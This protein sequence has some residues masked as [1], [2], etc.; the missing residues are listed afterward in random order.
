MSGR[1]AIGYATTKQVARR[2]LE[3]GATTEHLADALCKELGLPMPR[4]AS[5]TDSAKAAKFGNSKSPPRAAAPAPRPT[6]AQPKLVGVTSVLRAGEATMTRIKF[7]RAALD[8]LKLMPT[9]ADA[10]PLLQV[11]T[12]NASAEQLGA[13]II[14]QRRFRS[15]RLRRHRA[16][17]MKFYLPRNVLKQ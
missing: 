11:Y 5:K 2:L 14:V 3:A 4:R 12:Q 15:L 9:V 17:K 16:Q 6:A 1:P 13:S 10:A 7:L 8:P